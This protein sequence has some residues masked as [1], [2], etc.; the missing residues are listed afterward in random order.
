MESTEHVLTP[1]EARSFILYKTR[2]K[3]L[4]IAVGQSAPIAG[5]PGYCFSIAGN[6]PVTR[7]VALKFMTDAYSEV[8]ASKGVMCVIHTLS[9]CVFIGRAA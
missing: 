7:K 1:D 5:K 3:S 4:F 9:N 2:G 6:V 8:M